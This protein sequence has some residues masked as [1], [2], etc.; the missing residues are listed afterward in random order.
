MRKSLIAGIFAVAVLSIAP[1]ALSQIQNA[2]STGGQLQGV[3][4]DG[5]ASFK[6]IPF[7]APPVGDLRWKAPEPSK[8]WN[9]IRKADAYAPGCMQDSSMVKMVGA[10]VGVSEDCLYLNVWTAAKAA[11]EK[12]PVMVWIHGGAF[13]GGMTGTPMFDGTKFA[14]KG[15]VLVSIAYR[16]GVFG[17]MAHPQLSRE[18]A[19]GS[20]A[21]GIQDMIAG[22]QWVKN[23]IAQFGG[24]PSCVTI[25]GESA[26]GIAVGM[27]SAAP[28]AKGLFQRAISESGGSFAPPRIADEAGQNVPS[29]KLA[30][31][32]GESFLK[33][34]G[35]ADIKAARALPA[36]QILKAAGGGMGGGSSFWPVADGNAIPGDPYELYEKGRFNDTPILVGTNSNEGGLFSRGPVTAAAFEQQIRSGYGEKAD[37][38]LG[39]YP[40]STDAE[41]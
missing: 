23:N 27:L 36:E 19:K 3:V 41:A 18:S 9:G 17:F 39:A 7:A 29:L 26:G 22:L 37:V 5:V 24:D 33:K 8:A 16:L 4:V 11:G 15:V 34:L 20:G 28:A 32:N 13:V 14:Q 40:H 1:F 10:S 38:I 12:R 25:F 30:E 21:Y 2:K 31:S 35:V 6:G